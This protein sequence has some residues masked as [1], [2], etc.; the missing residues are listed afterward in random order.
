MADGREMSLEKARR[1]ID[2]DRLVLIGLLSLLIDKDIIGESD[3][4]SLRNRCEK[5]LKGMQVPGEPIFQI[6]SEEV[7]SELNHLLSSF[8]SRH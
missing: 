8:R 1:I 3:M 4:D 2:V 7:A 6:H 5:I